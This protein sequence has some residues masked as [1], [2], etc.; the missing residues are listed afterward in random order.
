LLCSIFTRFAVSIVI[1]IEDQ[2]TVIFP[3]LHITGSKKQS[4]ERAA[5]LLSECM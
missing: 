2:F 5:F 1:F 4:E 3:T